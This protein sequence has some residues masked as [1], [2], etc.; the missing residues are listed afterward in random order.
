LKGRRRIVNG[1]VPFP[2][3]LTNA[4]GPGKVSGLVKTTTRTRIAATPFMALAGV[5]AIILFV[6]I[7]I[8]PH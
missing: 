6:V 4:D 1:V 3:D 2:G 5:C 7:S 8:L